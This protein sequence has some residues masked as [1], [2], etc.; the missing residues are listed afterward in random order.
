LAF[1]AVQKNDTD[2]YQVEYTLKDVV[3]TLCMV[4]TPSAAITISTPDEP[5]SKDEKEGLL[6]TA[7]TMTLV[8]QKPLTSSIRATI[9]HLVSQGGRTARF[10]GFR[11]HAIWAFAITIVANSLDAVLP[12]FVPFRLAVISALAGAATAN[13]HAAWTHKVVSMPST[14]SFWQRVPARSTWKVLALPA[15]VYSAMPYISFYIAQ[16]AFMTLFAG[17]DARDVRDY[18][19]AEWTSLIFRIIAVVVIAVSCTLFLCLPAVVTMVRVEASILPEEEDTIVPFDRTFDG[20]VVSKVLGGTGT[21]GFIDAWKSF[22][23]EARRRLLKLYVKIFF[24]MMGLSFLA[25]HVWAVVGF[26]ALGPN[27]SKLIAQA[28]HS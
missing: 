20:K 13:L 19:G 21:I 15:A 27:L 4:E 3:A 24:I 22:N 7:P 6:E 1:A 11:F 14:T 28:R 12:A 2:N 16:L 26:V 25:I 5:A 9:K 10:R 23:W 8:H 18:T 17:I